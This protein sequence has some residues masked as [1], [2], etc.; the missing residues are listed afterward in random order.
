MSELQSVAS[1]SIRL[2]KG[3]SAGCEDCTSCA[4]YR[5][6][7]TVLQKRLSVLYETVNYHAADSYYRILLAL[8][9]AGS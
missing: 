5:L 6:L 9:I 7:R 2:T 3:K 4:L 1:L 8:N